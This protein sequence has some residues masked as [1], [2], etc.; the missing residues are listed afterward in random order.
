MPNF[1]GIWEIR[2]FYTATPAGLLVLDH[3][4][5]FDVAVFGDPAPGTPMDGMDV[6]RRDSSAIDLQSYLTTEFMPLIYAVYPAVSD[7]SRA[8]LWKIPEATF[9]AQFITSL[10]LAENGVNAAASVSMQ[11]T[12]FTFRS[13]SG[14][15]ARIQLMESSFGGLTKQSPPFSSAQGNAL[16]NH[17][18]S[19]DSCIV[20]RDNSYLISRI[21]QCDGQ[22]ERIFR[23][24]NRNT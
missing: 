1:D 13:Q 3:V 21:H 6:T 5:T 24:R 15:V 11:Q 4:M 8:E 22:N 23:K 10:E 20:A 18:I 14:G 2:V 17:I 16:S 9:D 19:S 7:F 12:T